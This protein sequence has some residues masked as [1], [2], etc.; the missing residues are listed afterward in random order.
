MRL[1]FPPARDLGDLL[2]AATAQPPCGVVHTAES[3]LTALAAGTALNVTWTMADAH[4]GGFRLELLRPLAA[5]SGHGGAVLRGPAEAVVL[6]ILAQDGAV[7]SIYG[8]TALTKAS[9]QS[10]GAL[11][12][13]TAQWA[14]VSLPPR[15]CYGCT[16]RLLRQAID[17]GGPTYTQW[18]CADVNIMTSGVNPCHNCAGSDAPCALSAIS[19][20][21]ECQCAAQHKGDMP[22]M[23]LQDMTIASARGNYYRIQD[24][25]TTASHATPVPDTKL[26][27]TNDILDV[28]GH[29]EPDGMTF[30]KFRRPFMPTDT[31]LCRLSNQGYGLHFGVGKGTSCNVDSTGLGNNAATQYLKQEAAAFY[32]PDELKYHGR[33]NAGSFGN[34]NLVLGASTLDGKGCASVEFSLQAKT[35]G[36]VALG[37]SPN[38]KMV[39]SDAIVGFADSQNVLK[40]DASSSLGTVSVYKLTGYT[41][42]Q[43]VAQPNLQVEN[44]SAVYV[45][46][47]TILRFA[48]NYT[49]GNVS[50]SAGADK[51]VHIIWATSSK[52]SNVLS[53]HYLKNRYVCS[54]YLH[55][56]LATLC[57]PLKEQFFGAMHI[58]TSLLGLALVTIGTLIAFTKFISRPMDAFTTLHGVSSCAVLVLLLFEVLTGIFCRPR[59]SDKGGNLCGYSHKFAGIAIIITAAA[60][61]F[62]GFQKYSH[63]TGAWVML[64][65]IIYGACVVFFLFL[66]LLLQC[67]VPYDAKTRLVAK[68]YDIVQASKRK[69]LAGRGWPPPNVVWPPTPP[70]DNVQ[71]S[72]DSGTLA[73]PLIPATAVVSSNLHEQSPCHDTVLP[74]PSAQPDADAQVVSTRVRNGLYRATTAAEESPWDSMQEVQSFELPRPPM[75][76]HSDVGNAAA[77]RQ[78]LVLLSPRLKSR[79]PV[80]S[81]ITQDAEVIEPPAIARRHLV[82]PLKKGGRFGPY[83]V[84]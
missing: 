7:S 69:A 74:P 67:A 5:V 33:E 32:R 9:Q 19:D 1:A 4:A 24:S 20:E 38:G 68:D 29:E 48:R 62:L 75:P 45:N 79:P 8:L 22:A 3:P 72:P 83:C 2:D 23:Y 28:I 63:L 47:T 26:G 36:W 11:S 55:F 58:L 30:V 51:G 31:G 81:E 65:V 53:N 56:G 43:V 64:F 50:I 35:K 21:W 46:K 73:R 41:F 59:I 44:A 37:F 6:E 40:K 66:Y 82:Q 76:S 27:G 39:G 13:P 10:W 78:H 57:P 54:C 25:W 15:D 16:I 14:L 52:N 61:S 34:V 17:I 60:S 70:K 42:T 49:G 84:V 77:G 80:L 71:D 18:S 12:N